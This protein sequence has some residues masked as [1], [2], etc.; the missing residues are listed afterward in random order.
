MRKPFKAY[1][2][3]GC[4]K[5]AANF[6]NHLK[7]CHKSL[8]ATEDDLNITSANIAKGSSTSEPE[9]KERAST[10]ESVHFQ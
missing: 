8:P 3:N 9:P 1:E 6:V 2:G 4:W 10:S 5:L 7:M